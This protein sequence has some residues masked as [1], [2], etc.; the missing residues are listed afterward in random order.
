MLCK[1]LGASRAAGPFTQDHYPPTATV[2]GH[3]AN[4]ISIKAAI[5]ESVLIKVSWD[6]RPPRASWTCFEGLPEWLFSQPHLFGCTCADP[7]R[8]SRR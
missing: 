1:T 4:W 6:H 7:H 5:S 3:L 8:L 2:H